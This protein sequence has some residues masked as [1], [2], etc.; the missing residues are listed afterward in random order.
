MRT[1]VQERVKVSSGWWSCIDKWFRKIMELTNMLRALIVYKANRP[2]VPL[3]S[4]LPVKVCRAKARRA[5]TLTPQ[6]VD[7]FI[8]FAMISGHRGHGPMFFCGFQTGLRLSELLALHW[9]DINWEQNVIHVQRAV[10]QRNVRPTKSG[11]NRSVDMSEQLKTVLFERL[12][13]CKQDAK[14]TGGREM[15][16]II[17]D[18]NGNYRSEN[19]IRKVFSR[20]LNRAGL[21]TYSIQVMRNTYASL[22]I[23]RGESLA[24]VKDQLGHSSTKLTKEVYG[25][26]LPHVTRRHKT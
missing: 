8:R 25:H 2:S 16:E 17:F 9:G 15:S 19:A 26:L 1:I 10:N 5:E 13:Q 18:S 4:H 21:R 11:G 7:E 23:S 6:E 20:D 22:L 14:K 24:Y 3:T 12:K